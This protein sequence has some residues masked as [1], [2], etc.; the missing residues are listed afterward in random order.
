[1]A[2]YRRRGWFDGKGA[3]GVQHIQAEGWRERVSGGKRE[4]EEGRRR[5]TGRKP[6][7][8]IG[9]RKIEGGRGERGRMDRAG[10]ECQGIEKPRKMRVRP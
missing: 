2:V 3:H 10:L 6:G 7:D 4:R 1:M 5:E 8:A 9:G